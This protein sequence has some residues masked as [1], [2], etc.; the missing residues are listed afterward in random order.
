M[1]SIIASSAQ[2]HMRCWTLAAKHLPIIAAFYCM[3]V[4]NA[5]VLI[6]DLFGSS[7]RNAFDLSLCELFK[8]IG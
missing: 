4:E 7:A 1:H 6:S 5:V 2:L 8:V 3:E